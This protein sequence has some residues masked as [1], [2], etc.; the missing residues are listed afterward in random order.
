MSLRRKTAT[1]PLDPRISALEEEIR[2]ARRYREYDAPHASLDDRLDGLEQRISNAGTG[3]MKKSQYDTDGDGKVDRA[4]IADWSYGVDWL[5]VHNKP[6]IPPEYVL[7]VATEYRLGGIKSGGDIEVQQD[8]TIRVIRGGVGSAIEDSPYNGYIRVDGQDIEVYRH[9]DNEHI[10]HVTDS[11]IQYWNNK[12][13]TNTA[14]RYS[15]GLLSWEDKRKLDEL[16]QGISESEADEKYADKF[17]T[18]IL[19]TQLS[20]GFMSAEDK[21]KLDN[22]SSIDT[23]GFATKDEMNGLALR[24]DNFENGGGGV[25]KLEEITGTITVPADA[26]VRQSFQT[27]FGKFDIRTIKAKGAN[28]SPIVVQIN[29]KSD[30]TIPVYRSNQETVVEDNALVPYIDKENQNKLH[31][32]IENKGGTSDIITFTI[33]IVQLI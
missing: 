8:G 28:N 26:I 10:R 5:D 18:H 30:G 1:P 23:S 25:P 32:Q 15:D 4:E 3:D 13:S 14:T 27:S 21:K 33:K 22:L 20:N 29:E 7:P 19:A 12:A 17:H 11:Q 9:P 24:L 6:Y 16:V 31:L 2:R